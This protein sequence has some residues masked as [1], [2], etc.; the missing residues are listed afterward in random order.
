MP[1][2]FESTGRDAL[3]AKTKAGSSG[4]AET[5]L[6]KGLGKANSDTGLATQMSHRWISEALPD[7]KLSAE[8]LLFASAVSAYKK[9]AALDPALKRPYSRW[10]LMV[11]GRQKYL[12]ER[13]QG[14]KHE[15][16][17]PCVDLPD[18][19]LDY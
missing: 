3:P 15:I 2:I 12:H 11:T 18:N 4:E 17:P 7:E 13:K 19:V 14:H 10:I 8:G 6:K 5:E 9:R 1:N 16:Q